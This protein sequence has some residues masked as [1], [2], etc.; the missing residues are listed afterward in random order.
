MGRYGALLSS[1]ILRPPPPTPPGPYSLPPA[2]PPCT[3]RGCLTAPGGSPRLEMESGGSR[4]G[5]P[6]SRGPEEGVWG[7]GG[8]GYWRG[9]GDEGGG[10][11]RVTVRRRGGGRRKAGK[12]GVGGDGAPETEPAQTGGDAGVGAAS[13]RGWEWVRAPPP[14]ACEG[15]PSLRRGRPPKAPRSGRGR[16]S[17]RTGRD[18]GVPGGAGGERGSGRAGCGHRHAWGPRGGAGPGREG[19]SRRNARHFSLPF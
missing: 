17:P 2:S 5:S 16:R 10:C 3:P 9:G 13:F 15:T 1:F 8:S 14:A 7:G 19:R 6:T 12:K 11:L 18:C 4:Q